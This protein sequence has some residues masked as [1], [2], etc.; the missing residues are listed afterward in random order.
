M[1]QSESDERND[2]TEGV[3]ENEVGIVFPCLIY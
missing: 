2:S 3:V 1:E